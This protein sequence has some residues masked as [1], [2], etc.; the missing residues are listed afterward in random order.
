MLRNRTII[1][2]GLVVSLLLFA[3][4]CDGALDQTPPAVQA[5]YASMPYYAPPESMDLC[6][7]E[8]PLRV[9]DVRERFDREFTLVVYNHAQ[10]ILWLKRK[11]RYFP[12]LERQLAANNL[13]DDL[14]YVTIA[15]TDLLLSKASPSGAM[16]PWQFVATTGSLYNLAQS[17][18]VDE[19]HDLD[20]S[21]NGTFRHLVDL[22]GTFQSWTLAVA[23]HNY[24]EKRLQEEM[25]KQRADNY[26]QL[27]LPKETERYVFKVLAIKEVLNH[28]D[29]YGYVLP[30]GA[31]YQSVHGDRV[32]M[33]LPSP[34]PIQSAAEAAA[35]QSPKIAR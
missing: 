2:L 34:V 5:S 25:K 14:K 17:R 21:T 20:L 3:H 24:G 16:G 32:S 35:G 29:R 12:W 6:G 13:P 27:R 22:H 26:Y 18:N 9:Q 19:R 4:L 28:P 23:A 1:A 31:G 15:E 8:V 33:R 7:E 11:D 30:R 10:V